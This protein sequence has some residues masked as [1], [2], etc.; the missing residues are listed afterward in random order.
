MTNQNEFKGA[1]NIID[2]K[3]EYMWNDI[4]DFTKHHDTIRRALMIASKLMEPPSS[5]MNEVICYS[6]ESDGCIFKTIRDQ[7]LAETTQQTEMK[8]K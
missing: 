6:I 4:N 3:S 7:L 2:A 5:N 8:D 1:L